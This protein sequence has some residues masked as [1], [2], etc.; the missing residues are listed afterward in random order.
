MDDIVKTR[1]Y[2]LAQAGDPPRMTYLNIADKT[3]DTVHAND[4]SSYEEINTLIQ[5]EPA[6]ALDP[7]RAGQCAAIGIV[8][9]QPFAPDG[10]MRRI[11]SQ[12]A[13]LAAAARPAPG[14][15][16]QDL[17]ARRDRARHLTPS[18]RARA[19]APGPG[20]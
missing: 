7:E 13:P 6:G 8:K 3:Q 15:V 14:L 1:V 11:L 16:R 17:A 12:A 19:R 2:P 5:E 9:G 4:F 20:W 10:R 18:H